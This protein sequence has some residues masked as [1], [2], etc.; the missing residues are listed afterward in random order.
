MGGGSP[1]APPPQDLTKELLKTYLGYA[2]TAVPYLHLEQALQPAY[3]QL[4]LDLLGQSLL[5]YNIP[6]GG[7]APGTSGG[8]PPTG[9]GGTPFTEGG[10]GPYRSYAASSS[11]Y[12]LYPSPVIGQ[13]SGGAGSGSPYSPYPSP[14][15]GQTGTSPWS[16][17]APT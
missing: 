6:G 1:S 11:P 9:G 15:I 13:G 5:G 8:T 10:G 3:G 4:N 2:N 12:P 17:I 7:T 14:L 16:A